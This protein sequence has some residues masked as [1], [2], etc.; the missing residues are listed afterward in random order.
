[1]SGLPPG[2]M[3]MQL[4]LFH[5]GLA[6][7]A[8]DGQQTFSLFGRQPFLRLRAGGLTILLIGLLLIR[9][10]GLLALLLILR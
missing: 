7:A 3:Y 9:L 2:A 4:Q 8:D 5:Q 1:M 10:T 6:V